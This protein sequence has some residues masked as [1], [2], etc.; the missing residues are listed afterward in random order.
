MITF[1]KFLTLALATFY[2]FIALPPITVVKANSETYARILCEDAVIYHDSNLSQPIFTLPYSYY[3]KIELESSNSTKISFGD[4]DGVYPQI[5]GYINPNKLTFINYVPVSPYPK[6]KVSTDV[7]DVLFND[8]EQKKP[9]FNIP[10]NEVMYYYGETVNLDKTLCYVYYSKKLGYVDKISLN[11]FSVPLHPDEIKFSDN[12]GANDGANIDSES[13][14]SNAIG[15]NMQIAIIVGISI[16][17]IS[18]V[19]FLFK[20]SKNKTADEQSEFSNE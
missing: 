20:P 15:E 3:V 5:I 17:C 2:I 9:Y 8:F 1:R 4:S 16:I 10:M 14:P 11:P 19:Y 7:S 6:I 12:G 13:T 18:V